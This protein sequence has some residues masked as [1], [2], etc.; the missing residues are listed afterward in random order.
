MFTPD[1]ATVTIVQ[2][3]KDQDSL[4]VFDIPN[5]K[6]KP[7]IDIG[8]I[9]ATSVQ[10]S[11]DGQRLA[12]VIWASQKPFN[13]VKVEVYELATGKRHEIDARVSRDS[14]LTWSPDGKRLLVTYQSGTEIEIILR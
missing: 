6:E 12:A 4:R 2:R 9:G 11:P 5:R 1:G 8:G 7:A 3:I 13:P 10:L 14:K